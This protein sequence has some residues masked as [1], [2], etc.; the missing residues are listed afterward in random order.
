MSM[1]NTQ[2][3]KLKDEIRASE[4]SAGIQLYPDV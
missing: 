2:G 4:S 1:F 3:I